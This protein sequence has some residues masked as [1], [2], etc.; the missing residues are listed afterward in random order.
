MSETAYLR[1]SKPHRVDSGEATIRCKV[2]STRASSVVFARHPILSPCL[3]DMRTKHVL[4]LE[5]FGVDHPLMH[6]KTPRSQTSL[7]EKTPVHALQHSQPIAV[8]HQTKVVTKVIQIFQTRQLLLATSLTVGD[9]QSLFKVIKAGRVQT[10]QM[11]RKK[12]GAPQNAI[13]V[14]KTRL[15]ASF[16]SYQ[17]QVWSL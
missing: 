12:G 8:V 3:Q 16:E 14:R 2:L 17:G 15:T 1:T 13:I 6:I 4:Q 9:K 11:A 5:T 10:L 7:F